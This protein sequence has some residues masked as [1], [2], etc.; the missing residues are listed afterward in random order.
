LGAATAS[1]SGD[2]DVLAKAG[3]AAL[4]LLASQVLATTIDAA[5]LAYEDVPQSRLSVGV[6]FRE[7]PR[8][9]RPAPAGL[10]LTLRF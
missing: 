1:G 7:P 4:G 6:L 10:A 9:A 2:E 3:G 8:G 5:A